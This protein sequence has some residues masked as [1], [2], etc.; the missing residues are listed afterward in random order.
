[1]KEGK[2]KE[3]EEG[4]ERGKSGEFFRMRAYRGIRL[5]RWKR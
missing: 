3:R 4:K 2:G 1:M 5:R